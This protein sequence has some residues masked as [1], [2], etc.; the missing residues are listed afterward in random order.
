MKGECFFF[1][2]LSRFARGRVSGS[3]AKLSVDI[4]LFDV[5]GMIAGWKTDGYLE[6]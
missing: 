2:D 1:H 5:G 3:D 4:R 6:I